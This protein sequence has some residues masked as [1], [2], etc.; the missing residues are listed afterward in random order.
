MK[1]RKKIVLDDWDFRALAE[2]GEGRHP[3]RKVLEKKENMTS[4]LFKKMYYWLKYPTVTISSDVGDVKELE[5]MKE[6][7]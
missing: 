1:E 3:Y 7:E 6:D 5:E 2:L 4:N